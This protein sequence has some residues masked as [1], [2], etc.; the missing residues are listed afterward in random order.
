MIRRR[1]VLV[2]AALS[3]VGSTVVLARDVRSGSTEPLTPG[4]NVSIG[5]A[6]CSLIGTFLVSLGKIISDAI[7]SNKDRVE[8]DA[9]GKATRERDLA[10]A[11][12][13]AT[14]KDLMEER[15]ARKIADKTAEYWR[16]KYERL[17]VQYAVKAGEPP[18]SATDIPVAKDQ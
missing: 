4:Q 14:G 11:C 8:R 16:G 6:I 5:I 17:A 2:L 10:V 3:L 18:K 9:V 7:Q 12:E 1:S 13:L 15:E